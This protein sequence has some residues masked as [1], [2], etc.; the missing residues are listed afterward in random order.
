MLK[1]EFKKESGETKTIQKKADK[2]F[3]ETDLKTVWLKFAEKHKPYQATY[4]LLTQQYDFID[5]KVIVHLHN[6]FQETLLNEIRLDLLTFL[7]EHLQND[8]IQLSGEVRVLAEED[9]S[10]LYM[11]DKERLNIMMKKNPLVRE[12]K[13]KFGLDTDF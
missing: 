13:D 1:G 8:N 7:R 9:R 5:N 12:L 2:P 4:Q 6:H 10:H 3:T 11:N